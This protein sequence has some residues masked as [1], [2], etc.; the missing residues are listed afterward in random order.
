MYGSWSLPFGAN[1]LLFRNVTSPIVKRVMEGWNLSWILTLQSGRRQSIGDGTAQMMGG[2]NSPNYVAQSASVFDPNNN[3]VDFPAGAWAGSYFK[4]K[5]LAVT[6]PSCKDETL[7]AKSLSGTATCTALALALA[8]PDGL[9]ASN[10]IVYR[11]S[12]PGTNGNVGRNTFEGIGMFS[13]DM[14]MGKSVALTEGKSLTIR[15]D[16]QNILNHPTPS[17]SWS[18]VNARFTQISDPNFSFSTS[19]P[20]GYI[21][22][23]GGHRTFQGQIRLQF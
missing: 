2:T 22:T 17:N 13:L 11:Q 15:V 4:T 5:L 14:N 16:A 8:N 1:G 3:G 12:L 20:L 9:T 21:S 7:V 19:Q 10:Y 23:K 6:D 18:Q